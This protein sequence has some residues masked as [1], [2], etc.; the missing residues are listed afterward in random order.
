MSERVYGLG[1]GPW[2]DKC[3]RS[4]IDQSRLISEYNGDH[5]CILGDFH[6]TRNRSIL[7]VVVVTVDNC[8]LVLSNVYSYFFGRSGQLIVGGPGMWWP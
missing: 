8:D 3:V 2:H 4:Q 5:N 7:T 1:R 6:S